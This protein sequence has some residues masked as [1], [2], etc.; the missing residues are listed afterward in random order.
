MN[1]EDTRLRHSRYSA[2]W[3]AAN[4]EKV[5]AASASRYAA[6]PE[7]A[8]ARVRA[9]YAA[10]RETLRTQS[11]EIGLAKAE[12]L[13]G[14]PCPA[15]CEVCNRP[16]RP[17][18]FGRRLH[19]DHD[20]RTGEFR[21]WLCSRCNTVLGKVEDDAVVL[22]QLIVYLARSRRPKLLRRSA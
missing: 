19:F 15:L 11:R 2:R 10:N 22:D 6:N 12:A 20:H 9:R 1:V 5:L 8:N 14:R 3:Y 17:N 16:P 13:A 21:G 7:K 18:D 4:R